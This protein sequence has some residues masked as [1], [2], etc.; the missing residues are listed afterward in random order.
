MICM[1]RRMLV[2]KPVKRT[3]V[4]PAKKASPLAKILKASVKLVKAKKTPIQR[5]QAELAN[6]RKKQ[7]DAEIKKKRKEGEQRPDPTKLTLAATTVSTRSLTP[8]RLSQ[9]PAAFGQAQAKID[10][11]PPRDIYPVTTGK[12]PGW[13][14]SKV[15]SDYLVAE[16]VR[17]GYSTFKKSV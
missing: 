16:L 8:S 12:E 2:A 1:N 11:E 15:H 9:T 17:R 10:S 7:L 14:L 4:K 3:P 13:D 6:D 5:S